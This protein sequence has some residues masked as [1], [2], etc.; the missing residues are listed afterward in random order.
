[1]YIDRNKYR[2]LALSSPN[3]Y[4]DA[5]HVV[6]HPAM[7]LGKLWRVVCVHHLT[8][9]ENGNN[10]NV[11]A[12]LLDEN[13]NFIDRPQERMHYGWAGQRADEVSPP[14]AFDKS[15]DEPR[16]NMSVFK[17]AVFEV[18]LESQYPSDLV[19]GLTTDLPD[20]GEYNRRFHHSYYIIW[21]LQ[22]IEVI[23]A[24][25]DDEDQ[26]NNNSSG[27]ADY[28]SVESVVNALNALEESILGYVGQVAS[29]NPVTAAAL[30]DVKS[31]VATQFGEVRK[32][33]TQD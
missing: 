6:V 2:E 5:P 8:P 29:V 33:L 19:K 13:G 7:V 1:M 16:T 15:G 4:N 28:V 11:Y 22:N 30:S 12:D 20:E 24:D 17:G 14:V 31:M 3:G 27:N 26:G 23:A 21:Q 18:F 32:K 25:N 10:H 9:E